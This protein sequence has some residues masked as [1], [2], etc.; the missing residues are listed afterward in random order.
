VSV[1]VAGDHDDRHLRP[2]DCSEGEGEAFFGDAGG[3]EQVADYQKHVG[4][5]VVGDV[6]DAAERAPN[7]VAQL[8]ASLA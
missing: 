5:A 8:Y 6:D 1:V 3:I 2:G 4:V 7:F